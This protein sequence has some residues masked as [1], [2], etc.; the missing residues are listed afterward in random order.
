M[1]G[2]ID[3]V[4]SCSNR[5]RYPVPSSLSL[6]TVQK[7]A[8][9]RRASNWLSKLKTYS[10]S[11]R[12][13][14][15]VYGGD[16]WSVVRALTGPDSEYKIQ[17]RVWICSAGYGLIPYNASIKPYAATFA[18]G[19]RDSVSFGKSSGQ[20]QIDNQF[21]W[22]SLARSWEGPA[23]GTP[24]SLHAIPTLCGRAPMLIAL[25]SDY[26]SAV[27]RDIEQLLS[28]DYYRKH[29]AIVSCG[30]PKLDGPLASNLLP[31]DAR[32]Q[33]AVGGVRAS[34]NVRIAAHL[35]RHLRH[36]S[37]SYTTLLKLSQRIEKKP[38][39]K[40]KRKTLSDDAVRDFISRQLSR[41]QNISRTS[42]LSLLRKQKFACE[43]LRF[44]RLFGPIAHSTREV[45][46]HA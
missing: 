44:A 11:P 2:V 5:K 27:L 33:S 10:V 6:H 25:S 22:Q 3:V 23:P 15:S 34:L 35:L 39:A 1:A 45:I 9:D 46:A 42:L 40:L 28:D 8:V 36:P 19:H 20:I 29:L 7:D 38:I 37:P 30:T 4:V 43:Q 18:S 12:P 17:R 31:C 13:V 16:H 21:W 14:A 41:D 32:M 26:L 24:R